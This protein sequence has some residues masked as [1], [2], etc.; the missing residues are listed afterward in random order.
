MFSSVFDKVVSATAPDT[1]GTFPPRAD[2]PASSST[3][4]C[5]SFADRFMS[6]YPVARSATV[7]DVVD[8]GILL[9][10]TGPTT[11]IAIS[12]GDVETIMVS[13]AELGGRLAAALA[14]TVR[15]KRR[16]LETAPVFDL[17]AKVRGIFGNRLTS[18]GREIRVSRNAEA[19]KDETLLLRQI[20][21]LKNAAMDS[22]NGEKWCFLVSSGGESLVVCSVPLPAVEEG[23]SY[24]CDFLLFD[25]W[26]RPAMKLRGSYIV[27]FTTVRGLQLHIL[28]A[29]GEIWRSSGLSQENGALKKEFVGLSVVMRA[30]GRGAEQHEADVAARRML[31]DSV[32]A[33]RKAEKAA[34]IKIKRQEVEALRKALRKT[35]QQQNLGPS[36]PTSIGMFRSTDGARGPENVVNRNNPSTGGGVFQRSGHSYH[37]LEQPDEISERSNLLAETSTPG[38]GGAVTLNPHGD[39]VAGNVAEGETTDMLDSISL[40]VGLDDQRSPQDG[41]VISTSR[42]SSARDRRNLRPPAADVSPTLSSRRSQRGEDRRRRWSEEDDTTLPVDSGCS[43]GLGVATARE[44]PATASKREQEVSQPSTGDVH[45]ELVERPRQVVRDRSI[46]NGVCLPSRSDNTAV[47][48]DPLHRALLRSIEGEGLAEYSKRAYSVY[49]THGVI[50]DRT[51]ADE[52]LA[53]GTKSFHQLSRSAN[54]VYDHRATASPT[55]D[56]LDMMAPSSEKNTDVAG[57]TQLVAMEPDTKEVRG[58]ESVPAGMDIRSDPVRPFSPPPVSPQLLRSTDRRPPP[59]SDENRTAFAA[60]SGSDRRN[61]GVC[62]ADDVASYITKSKEMTPPSEGLRSGLRVPRAGRNL[63]LTSS[64]AR[65]APGDNREGRLTGF[66]GDM[67]GNESAPPPPATTT[68]PTRPREAWTKEQTIVQQH[69][70]WNLEE[71]K[72]GPDLSASTAGGDAA[73]VVPG[74]NGDDHSDRASAAPNKPVTPGDGT[75]GQRRACRQAKKSK[76]S[77]KARKGAA[78]V[79]EARVGCDTEKGSRNGDC[80]SLD[81]PRNDEHALEAE[82]SGGGGGGRSKGKSTTFA[83]CI[84][85]TTLASADSGQPKAETHQSQADGVE[86][87]ALCLESVPGGASDTAPATVDPPP[88]VTGADGLDLVR[89][90]VTNGT[91]SAEGHLLGGAGN[92]S[93]NQDFVWFGQPDT[94]QRQ[95]L[96]EG[97]DTGTEIPSRRNTTG[98]VAVVAKRS[99]GNLS[100][101][102]PQQHRSKARL[103]L[104]MEV[105]RQRDIIEQ[106]VQAR[107]EERRLRRARIGAEV[108][109]RIKHLCQRRTSSSPA[110]ASFSPAQHLP[111][112]KS[113]PPA[114]NGQMSDLKVPGDRAEGTTVASPSHPEIPVKAWG[115]RPPEVVGHRTEVTSVKA[116]QPDIAAP[117]KAIAIVGKETTLD[118]LTP[119]PPTEREGARG[120]ATAANNPWRRVVSQ[121]ETHLEGYVPAKREPTPPSVSFDVDVDG[122]GGRAERLDGALSREQ[123]KVRRQERFEA[124]RARKLVEAEERRRGQKERQVAAREEQRRQEAVAVAAAVAATTPGADREHHY[125]FSNNDP[126]RPHSSHHASAEVDASAS[127]KEGKGTSP[128]MSVLRPRSSSVP[129]NDD[130]SVRAGTRV[131]GDSNGGGGSGNAKLPTPGAGRVASP[132]VRGLSR[133]SN[134]KLVRNAINFLCLAGGHLQERKARALEALDS[135]PASNFVVL[136]AHTK[137][138]SF[139]GLYACRGEDDGSADRVF[140]LGPPYVDATMA[141]GFYKY[142]SA[143]REFREVHSKTLG[144]TTDAISM[145]PTRLKRPKGFVTQ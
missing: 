2:L 87:H 38:G 141:S 95:Q 115:S 62:E 143:A 123:D 6:H 45:S 113:V 53:P 104:Q 121:Q 24:G 130:G 105:R 57:N 98:A 9:G 3:L 101:S 15:S 100:F 124:L 138:L 32:T 125:H 116:I 129:R 133:R 89:T 17:L 13:A 142:N 26:P 70:N 55:T 54:Q 93:E 128:G 65:G 68:V 30:K 145:E 114:D 92:P 136:L 77:R 60:T 47:P 41:N 119:A 50:E 139:K 49:R 36:A 86:I 16:D 127:R 25:P 69:D 117:K 61:L 88:L 106:A 42:D 103:L 22:C 72:Q 27:K 21:A 82:R 56:E 79:R 67:R 131:L 90:G 75:S 111:P 107:E 84:P 52:Y 43:R 112:H 81:P 46:D 83:G 118:A 132:A 110:R 58:T 33:L 108:F 51:E 11:G 34:A 64:D 18:I 120:E 85:I 44:T 135:H 80:A 73:G 66:R 74:E 8:G 40:E 5:L 39:D 76:G 14:G 137:L 94:P 29:L 28:S 140:G 19:E 37:H 78:T 96:T 97:D 63:G 122:F 59:I 7:D 48:D 35:S 23:G 91:G 1:L 109:K 99:G 134:R 31:E 20:H 4:C 126:R 12:A 71:D 10:R 102:S 144:K